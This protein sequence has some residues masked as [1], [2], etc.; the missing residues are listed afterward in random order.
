MKNTYQ[1]K[2]I[3]NYLVQDYLNNKDQLKSLIKN[4]TLLNEM[5]ENF[6][7]LLTKTTT[8]EQDKA[9][10]DI[11]LDTTV[12]HAHENESSLSDLTLKYQFIVNSSHDLICL[13]NQN[14]TIEAINDTFSSEFNI[15]S[16]ESIGNT[17]EFVLGKHEYADQLAA[18]VRQSMKG[19]S[20]TLEIEVQRN[21][22]QT[23]YFE[24]TIYPCK[25]SNNTINCMA[26]IGKNI[27]E[28][29][30]KT[31]LIQDQEVLLDNATDIIWVCDMDQKV[32]F[33]NKS[34]EKLYDIS[35]QNA[36]GQKIKKLV[37]RG[38][39]SKQ[40]QNI[41]KEVLKTGEWRGHLQSTAP[42]GHQIVL[43]SR[44]SL[45]RD[46]S[47]NPR[48][49]LIINSN[50]SDLKHLEQQFVQS[51][52]MENIGLIT[53]GI[54]HDLNNVLA[55]FFMIFKTLDNNMQDKR[56]KQLIK[57]IEKSAE[58]GASLVRQILSYVRGLEGN[59]QALDLNY[60]LKDIEQLVQETFPRN[61]KLMRIMES[62]SYSTF[63]NPTQL[64]QIFL[65]LV[66]NA[67]D[68][69]PEGG[70]ITIMCEKEIIDKTYA[71]MEEDAHPGHYI[72]IAFSDTG[73]GIPKNIIDKIFTPLFTTKSIDKGT[74]LG[75]ST[76]K[77]IIKSHKGF[78][79]CRSIENVGTTFDLYFPFV[80]DTHSKSEE[81]EL[82]S[83][84]SETLPQGNNETVM[85]VENEESV[86]EIIA[87]GLEKNG[88]K[89]I[90]VDDG[91][92]AI[93]MLASHKKDIKLVLQDMSLPTLDG[94]STIKSLQKLNP[95]VRIIALTTIA[96]D[97]VTFVDTYGSDLSVQ[98][99]LFKPFKIDTLLR[100]IQQVLKS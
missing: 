42:D 65:N 36:L 47:N 37:L 89:T 29:K 41:Q 14:L 77:T 66:I 4:P 93:A 91:P 51:Q 24:W 25:I 48:A 53:S 67:R 83:I 78:I 76:V 22:K 9:D 3:S 17:L 55:P 31:D 84:A 32:T 5:L 64:H 80:N 58:R 63:G 56:S 88:Y 68:A 13:V 26:L 81:K 99:F 19:S 12:K 98:Q 94:K 11:I 23:Q 21:K 86:R 28:K 71:E 97:K 15:S 79:R 90:K 85:I 46:Q 34:S 73:M 54:V 70:T 49:F 72:H 8:I 52:R 16:E 95:S 18:A 39:Q 43:E 61:I 92:E 44:W 45:V 10:L 6:D 27:T 40:L 75:L 57:L 50:I 100:T 60:L 33:W 62:D 30:H 82:T 35:S 38:S 20:A 1:N 2:P 87:F 69:M 59:L 7:Q 74:G 96:F